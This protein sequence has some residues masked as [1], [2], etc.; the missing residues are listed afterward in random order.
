MQDT[1]IWLATDELAARFH[2]DPA[3]IRYWRHTGYGPPGTLFGKR[4]LYRLADVIAWEAQ[5][6]ADEP[7]RRER[8]AARKARRQAEAAGRPA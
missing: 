2:T 1:T 7:E 3:T 4:V 5:R 8:E 6:E